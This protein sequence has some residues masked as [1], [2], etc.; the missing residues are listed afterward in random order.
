MAIA[1]AVALTIGAGWLLEKSGVFPLSTDVW[2]VCP[3]D[4]SRC[5]GYAGPHTLVGFAGWGIVVWVVIGVAAVILR[6][7]YMLAWSVG[8]ELVE[9]FA[10]VRCKGSAT[11]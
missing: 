6:F 10:M 3:D 7:F 4:G 2:P 1:L 9:R 11:R 5:L 8:A